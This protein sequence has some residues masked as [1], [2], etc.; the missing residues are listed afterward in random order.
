VVGGAAL[1]VEMEAD[2]ALIWR[3]NRLMLAEKYGGRPSDIDE[4][5]AGDVADALEMMRAINKAQEFRNT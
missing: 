3:I 2:P 4:W 5:P 1:G